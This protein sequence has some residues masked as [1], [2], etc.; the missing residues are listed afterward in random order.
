M[1]VYVHVGDGSERKKWLV[2]LFLLF[3]RRL[4]AVGKKGVRRNATYW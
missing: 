4:S 2:A 3:G 1:A